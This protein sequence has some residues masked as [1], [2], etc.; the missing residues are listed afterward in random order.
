MTT[1]APDLMTADE[2]CKLLGLSRATVYA[3]AAA[4]DAGECVDAPP[5]YRLG[6]RR[7]RWDRGDVMEWLASQRRTA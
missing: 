3:W 5:H 7:I 4:R 2:V 1:E 6:V